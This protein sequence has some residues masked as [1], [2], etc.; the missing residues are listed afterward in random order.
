MSK[1]Q[2]FKNKEDFNNRED[3]SVNGVSQEY[4][5]GVE[6]E[7]KIDIITLKNLF[8]EFVEEIGSEENLGILFQENKLQKF[9]NKVELQKLSDG[10]KLTLDELNLI[11]CEGCWNCR[12]C[13]R[14]KN[15]INCKQNCENC[16]NCD[17]D[18]Y[19]CIKCIRCSECINCNE[20]K[21][22]EDCEN[23]NN[24]EGITSYKNINDLN[25]LN[26]WSRMFGKLQ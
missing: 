21:G 16:E 15:C 13:V 12:D 1:V 17:F 22:C 8:K 3:K 24:C 5:I 6:I 19:N 26:K 10:F 4:L 14:C 7:S 20:C 23:C 11:N 9:L 2:I 18:C 25:E